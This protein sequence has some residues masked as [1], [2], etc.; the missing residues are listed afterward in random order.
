M[1]FLLLRNHGTTDNEWFMAAEE[2]L[3]LM[4][5]RNNFPELLMYFFLT[6]MSQF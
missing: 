4:F 1:I 2:I 5:K 6:K 3:R